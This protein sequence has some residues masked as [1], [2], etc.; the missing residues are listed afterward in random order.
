MLRRLTLLARLYCALCLALALAHWLWMLWGVAHDRWQ[1]AQDCLTASQSE[2]MLGQ[3]R[4]LSPWW[5]LPWWPAHTLRL[6]LGLLWRGGLLA[7]AP[8]LWVLCALALR[9][10]DGARH[11][12]WRVDERW[13]AARS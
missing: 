3:C 2:P 9:V 10:L 12:L 7:F 11:W 8:W 13:R 5:R 6:A 1:R 4:A